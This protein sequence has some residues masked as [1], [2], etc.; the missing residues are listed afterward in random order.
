M[1]DTT[2]RKESIKRFTEYG[3]WIG[4]FCACIP[5]LMY[6]F[7]ST[8]QWQLQQH[9][10]EAQAEAASG[11]SS[12]G[13]DDSSSAAGVIDDGLVKIRIPAI[14]VDAMVVGDITKSALAEGPGHFPDSALP[15]QPGNC[16]IAAHRNV[17]GCWFANLDQLQPGDEVILETTTHH[18]HYTVT[19][20]ETVD[21]DNTSVLKSHSGKAELTLVT[22]TLPPTH[23][24]VVHGI[25]D[26][27]TT[28]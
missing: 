6:I 11:A 28:G 14:H 13:D 25:L 27:S 17:W 10:S 24:I 7:G 26:Q 16:A 12:T 1:N 3:F 21:P 9:W 8:R 15:G 20:Q 23:R 19:G 4:V 5:L 18:F 22:C 2:R